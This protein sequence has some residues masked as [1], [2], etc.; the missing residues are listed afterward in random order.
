MTERGIVPDLHRPSS[1]MA[2][3]PNQPDPADDTGLVAWSVSTAPARWLPRLDEFALECLDHDAVAARRWIRQGPRYLGGLGRQFR[4]VSASREF[5]SRFVERVR[6]RSAAGEIGVSGQIQL[7]FRGECD[8][9][10]FGTETPST[11]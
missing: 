1:P 7:S 3:M 2:A 6:E 9:F 5:G 8:G 4:L 11:H 10:N